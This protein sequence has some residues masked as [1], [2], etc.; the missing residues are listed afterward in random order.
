MLIITKNLFG[1]WLC[2]RQAGG[3]SNI[4]PAIGTFYGPNA[5]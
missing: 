2:P 5:G 4:N 1:P 3:N